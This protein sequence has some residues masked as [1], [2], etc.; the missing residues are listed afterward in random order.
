MFT[1]KEECV[2]Y[3]ILIQV[4]LFIKI[5]QSNLVKQNTFTYNKVKILI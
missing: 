4:N 1:L 5:L 2:S 3:K